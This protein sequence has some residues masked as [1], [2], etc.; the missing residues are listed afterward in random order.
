MNLI[1][2]FNEDFIS[3]S[4]VRLEGRRLDH[5]TKVLKSKLG[6]RLSVGKIDGRLGVGEIIRIDKAVELEVT[7][8]QKPPEPLGIKLVL[9]LPRPHLFKR[10][11]FFAAMLGIKEIYII[12]FSRVEKSLWNSKTLEPA[13]MQE[14][15]ILGLE[16]AKDT[17]L[18][19]ITV[20]RQFKPFLEDTLP[21]VIK[22]TTPIVAHPSGPE[23][24]PLLK[25]TPMTLVIGPEGGI[26]PHEL[27]Q[28]EKC[29]FKSMS[30]GPRIL[31][32]DAAL[33]FITSKLQ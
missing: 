16:Q 30:F 22:G 3:D 29:G 20:H 2:L 15:L 27:E 23:S 14:Q 7:F 6:D 5:V 17:I 8:N 28:L 24:S 26:I 11:L 19:S 25:P 4:R 31:R 33:A 12:N 32:V 21:N 1:L 18:P 9:A 13:V 10:S